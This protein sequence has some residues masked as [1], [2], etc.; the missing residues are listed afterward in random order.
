MNNPTNAHTPATA[1]RAPATPAAIR[2]ERVTLANGTTLQVRLSGPQPSHTTRVLLFVHG[3]PEA[4]FVWDALLAHF[5][6]PAHGGFLCI[7]P[8][9]RGFDDSDSPTDPKA[10]KPK[11]LV[12][13]LACLIDHYSQGPLAALIAH[14][15]GGAVSWN[16]ASSRPELMRG[17]LIINAPHPATLLRE[18]QTNTAQQAASAYM[19]YL[20]RDDAEQLLSA[21]DFAKL[22][23]FF[24]NDLDQTP[25][26]LTEATKNQYRDVWHKGL[27]GGCN[28]YRATPLR[29][30]THSSD[31]IQHLDIPPDLGRVTLPTRVLWGLL[32]KALQPGLLTGLE[33]HVPQ[34]TLQTVANASHWLVHEQPELVIQNIDALLAATHPHA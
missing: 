13:D 31:A 3:F 20:A 25:K 1:N 4:A 10:Y 9:L 22:W 19:N 18:L 5:S 34:L 17:L 8:N 7:A 33:H 11:Y 32:D 23:P 15:W 12:D 28:Y 27:T 2:H 21:N 30:A 26:W 16:L 14:D 24:N 29:P 6:Q